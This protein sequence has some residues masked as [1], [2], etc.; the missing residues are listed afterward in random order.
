M[1]DQQARGFGPNLEHMDCLI[2]KP[3]SAFA[4]SKEEARSSG[5]E[6]PLHTQ[7]WSTELSGVDLEWLF[8]QSRHKEKL[9]AEALLQAH[10]DEIRY[11]RTAMARPAQPPYHADSDDLKGDILANVMNCWRHSEAY[12]RMTG[13]VTSDSDITGEIEE[14]D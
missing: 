6:L 3:A 8:V 9:A 7:L 1:A 10:K 2:S 13:E 12:E 5:K 11:L 4:T 14:M